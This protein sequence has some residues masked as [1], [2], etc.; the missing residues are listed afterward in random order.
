MVN[1]ME[2]HC[3]FCMTTLLVNDH[4]RQAGKERVSRFA[5]M[6]AFYQLQPQSKVIKKVQSGGNN[7]EW[8]KASY[9]VAKQM[10]IMLGNLPRND[11]MVDEEGKF[12]RFCTLL[13]MKKQQL[14][15]HIKL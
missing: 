6:S 15:T 7:Q 11:I 14:Y 2:A 3:G 1:W 8:I 10:A 13:N 9:N 5:V 4:H 12:I